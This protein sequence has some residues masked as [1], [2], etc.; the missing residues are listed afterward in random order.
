MLILR[1]PFVYN[2][3][4][5]QILIT[6]YLLPQSYISPIALVLQDIINDLT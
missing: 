1:R 3:T 4:E 6:G 2:Y 5:C